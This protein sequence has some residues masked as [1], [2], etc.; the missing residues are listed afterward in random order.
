MPCEGWG[1]RGEGHWDTPT[2]P[3]RHAQDHLTTTRLRIM[4]TVARRMPQGMLPAARVLPCALSDERPNPIGGRRE[5][6]AC[7]RRQGTHHGLRIPWARP[8][9][10][11]RRPILQRGRQGRLAPRERPFARI[12]HQRHDQPTADQ[13]VSCLGTATML[14][15][16]V[17]RLL[18][19]AWD[20][21][22]TPPVSR[23]CAFW[24]VGSIQNTQERFVFQGFLRET[25]PSGGCSPV[26]SEYLEEMQHGGAGVRAS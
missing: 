23:S 6:P 11:Q 17:Q 24:D 9:H 3:T 25:P 10:P 13:K 21:C 14:L 15:E 16:R 18:S 8:H 5:R 20:A 2:A 26:T 4:L 19:F 22:G 12:A 1:N 7:G